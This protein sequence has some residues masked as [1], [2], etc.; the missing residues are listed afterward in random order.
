MLLFQ[1]FTDGVSSEKF[2]TTVT[3]RHRASS[4]IRH[5]SSW[6]KTRKYFIKGSFPSKYYNNSSKSIEIKNLFVI[7]YKRSGQ[8]IENRRFRHSKINQVRP[9]LHRVRIN[10]MVQIT[11]I[12]INCRLL[13]TE[14][15]YLGSRLCL[16][17]AIYVR[18][19]SSRSFWFHKIAIWYIF[20]L[21][22]LVTAWGLCFLV[23][24]KSI[25]YR[26]FTISSVHRMR[27]LSLNFVKCKH[28]FI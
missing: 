5:S 8:Y 26:R 7:M 11:G 17:R 1:T 3:Q 14:N 18:D 27:K 23:V 12:D 24:M 25:R 21:S 19:E 16:L 15:G 22:I 28:I 13:W 4:Q 2:N 10:S 9:T 6:Y 20:F